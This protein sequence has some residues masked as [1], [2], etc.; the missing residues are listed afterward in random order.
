M[1]F[2]VAM[3]ACKSTTVSGEDTDLLVLLLYHAATNHC[4]DISFQSDRRKQNVYNTT[5]LKCFVGG[6]V[7]S[8]MLLIHAF[9]GC[10]TTSRIF[11]VRKKYVVQKVMAGDSVLYEYSKVVRRWCPCILEANLTNSHHCATVS[12][13]RKWQH[14][15]GRFFGIRFVADGTF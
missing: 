12:L 4:K 2:T 9:S 15:I 1:Y 11:G 6:D 13:L 7:C 14:R 10:D 3:S 8:Y 5:V